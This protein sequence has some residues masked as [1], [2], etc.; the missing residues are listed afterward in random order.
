M[1]KLSSLQEKIAGKLEFLSSFIIFYH[2]LHLFTISTHPIKLTPPRHQHHQ[3]F[4]PKIWLNISQ[5]ISMRHITISKQQ[6]TQQPPFDDQSPLFSEI[7]NFL[8]QLQ[9]SNSRFRTSKVSHLSVS[10]HKRT[11]FK[12]STPSWRVWKYPFILHEDFGL[13]PLQY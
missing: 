1:H 2:L 8:I 13:G 9:S 12:S 5:N 10:H 3:V 11:L 6:Y 4:P 7:L